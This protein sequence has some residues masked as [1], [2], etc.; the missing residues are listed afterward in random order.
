MKNIN[1]EKMNQVSED[2][3]S[4]KFLSA[5]SKAWTIN[6]QEAFMQQMR[7]WPLKMPVMFIPA[8]WKA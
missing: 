3:P 5:A 7:K 8:E 6:M 2:G 4:G 1:P